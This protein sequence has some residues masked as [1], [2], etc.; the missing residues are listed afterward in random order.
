MRQTRQLFVMVSRTDT[1]IARAIRAVSRYPY[2][3]VSV[4]LDPSLSRWYSFA[5]YVRD[6][7][8]YSGFICETGE[9]FF[10]GAGDTQVRIYRLDI[11]QKKADA[12]EQLLPLAGDP[13]SGLIYN[14]F[15]ALAGVLGQRLHVPGCYTCLSFACELLDTHCASIE[16]LCQLLTPHLIYEGSFAALVGDSSPRD[17]L[18]FTRLG[19]LRGSARTLR[20]MT[21]LV[22]RTLCHGYHCYRELLFRSTVL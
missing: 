19:P 13:D 3:H 18:Y 5:R 20:Q 7:P 2:N 1:H 22:A 12:L 17:Q 6:T 16:Q 8:L 21:V 14:Y 4:T 15:D 11:P 9:R 10:A